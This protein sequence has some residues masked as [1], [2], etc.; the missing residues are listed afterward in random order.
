MHNKTTTADAPAATQAGVS[1][2]YA[3]GQFTRLFHGR[4][5][6][7]LATVEQVAS[8]FGR[9]L[10]ETIGI[11]INDVI[12]RNKANEGDNACASHDFCDANMV[13]DAAI[14]ECTGVEASDHLNDDAVLALWNAAWNVAKANGFRFVPSDPTV[15]DRKAGPLKLPPLYIEHST[16]NVYILVDGALHCAAMNA[17]EQP[18]APYPTVTDEFYPVTAEDFEDAGRTKA[19][20]AAIVWV[21]SGGAR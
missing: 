6:T 16:A 12:A 8:A 21:L 17:S 14:K 19:E 5:E 1:F 3:E 7:L 13:M 2:A 18:A 15:I 11:N 10:R 20:H 9:L 4:P